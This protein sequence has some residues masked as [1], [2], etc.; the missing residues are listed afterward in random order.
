MESTSAGFLA[1]IWENI[2]IGIAILWF[3]L[4]AIVGLVVAVRTFRFQRRRGAYWQTGR[5][6][7][8]SSRGDRNEAVILTSLIWAGL[9][10][11]FA[12]AMTAI[13]PVYAVEQAILFIKQL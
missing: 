9:L 2:R 5:E 3:G 13:L 12:F 11:L 6:R 4:A 7:Y 10:G 8:R 1:N